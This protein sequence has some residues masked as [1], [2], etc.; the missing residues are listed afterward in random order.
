[1]LLGVDQRALK[2][3]GTPVLAYAQK[4]TLCKVRM[5]ICTEAGESPSAQQAI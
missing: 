5:S 2:A 4:H 3:K 1:M